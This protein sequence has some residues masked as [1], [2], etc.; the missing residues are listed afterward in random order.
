ME[1]NN[2]E[3]SLAEGAV[4]PVPLDGKNEHAD[5]DTRN[6]QM[7]VEEAEGELAAKAQPANDPIASDKNNLST[8]EKAIDAQ[9]MDDI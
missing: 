9:P 2:Q 4:I 3:I 5:L 8:G 6:K 7:E 1:K